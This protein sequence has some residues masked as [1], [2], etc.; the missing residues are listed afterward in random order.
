MTEHRAGSAMPPTPAPS[1]WT[2]STAMTRLHV[3]PI[4]GALIGTALLLIALGL[5]LGLAS[6]SPT[7]IT[8]V[9][10][11]IDCGSV[12]SPAAQYADEA[13][14]VCAA[15]N[16]ANLPLSVLL[17]ASGLTTVLG[18]GAISLNAALKSQHTPV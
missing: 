4:A 2:A 15:A 3:K 5:F 1:D 7:L 12:F 11:P 17:I 13:V 14:A 8:D 18:V 6:A 16:G 10:S 9:A